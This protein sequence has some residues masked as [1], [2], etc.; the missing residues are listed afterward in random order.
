MDPII[1]TTSPE[2]SSGVAPTPQKGRPRKYKT[3]ELAKAAR[4]K[5]D[6]D[7]KHKK[8]LQTPPTSASQL[9]WNIYLKS[10]GLGTDQGLVMTDAPS[11]A[12]GTLITGGI[13]SAGCAPNGLNM[14]SAGAPLPFHKRN[15]NPG[16]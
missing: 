10:I 9:D 5:K 11:N 4:R 12:V 8:K 15:L 13:N 14:D 16:R 1:N 2:V 3:P 6:R 7:R